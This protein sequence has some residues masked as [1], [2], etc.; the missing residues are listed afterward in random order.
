MII[1]PS[2]MPT[3]SR[4][5][6]SAQMQS[7]FPDDDTDAAKE[8]TAAHWCA[9]Q[10]LRSYVSGNS[11][12][13]TN[14]L[15]GSVADNG[16]VV[17]EDMAASADQY[18]TDILITANKN[19]KL[20]QIRIEEKISIGKIYP[21]MEGTPD[22]YLFDDADNI[23]YVWDFKH[24]H[25]YVS[26]TSNDQ[27]ISYALGII[28]KLGIH[29]LDVM[30]KLIIVQPRCYTSESTVRDWSIHIND[31]APHADRLCRAAYAAM[32]PNPNTVS[33]DQC[34]Y[35]VPSYCKTAIQSGYNA[36]DTSG[37]MRIEVIPHDQ[38]KLQR[39]ILQRAKDRIDYQL[40]GVEAQITAAIRSGQLVNGLTLDNPPGRLEW[41]RPF[42][43]IK[44]LGEMMGVEL[45]QDKLKTPTQAKKLIDESVI[46][47]YSY[48]PDGKTKIVDSTNSRA[49]RVFSKS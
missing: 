40:S 8:G 6:G 22:C 11:I 9:E 5:A 15:I 44:L 28:D 27:L 34:R 23:L 43:E 42:K 13:L 38:L 24:G 48:R 17:S 18:V 4:C 47:A 35:C 33:G 37:K 36:I 20:S 29:N 45:T 10:S 19:G 14:D 30:V 3:I 7:I 32:Q 46:K 12:V 25:R 49:Q 2:A 26:A 1:R 16:L 21:G 41:N 31:L 39:E